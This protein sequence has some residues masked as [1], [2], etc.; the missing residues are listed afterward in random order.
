MVKAAED[1]KDEKSSKTLN[2]VRE[3]AKKHK[4]YIFGSI[5]EKTQDGKYYNTGI[6][7]N[8]KGELQETFRKMHLFDIDIPG[9]F[10]L[11]IF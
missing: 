4:V 10:L 7:I 5:P 3:L 8:P 1:F 11:S 6:V 2:L 9:R